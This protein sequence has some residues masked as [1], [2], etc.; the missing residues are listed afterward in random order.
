[1]EKKIM[2]NYGQTI[3]SYFSHGRAFVPNKIRN[4]QIESIF[5]TYFTVENF[6]KQQINS[7]MMRLIKMRLK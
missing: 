5:K 1:V 4:H 3:F 7:Q 6:K 2:T